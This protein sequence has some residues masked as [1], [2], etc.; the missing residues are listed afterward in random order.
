ML[1]D[2]TFNFNL[3]MNIRHVVSSGFLLGH[4]RCKTQTGGKILEWNLDLCKK[5]TDFRS[6]FSLA[7]IRLHARKPENA[8]DNRTNQ[9][10]NLGLSRDGMKCP[11]CLDSSPFFC[12]RSDATEDTERE[13][14]RKREEER[15]PST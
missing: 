13:R 10:E 12:I 7:H 11:I 2:K 15:E 1:A 6:T 9:M 4:R 3:R 14:E 5:E 8:W